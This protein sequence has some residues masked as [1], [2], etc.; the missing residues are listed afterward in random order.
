MFHAGF[1]VGLDAGFDVGFAEC[2]SGVAGLDERMDEPVKREM[3]EL[4]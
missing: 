1:R 3:M 4:K 2:E